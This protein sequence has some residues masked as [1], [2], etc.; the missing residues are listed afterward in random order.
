MDAIEVDD[1]DRRQGDVEDD[2]RNGIKSAAP[3][4]AQLF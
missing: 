3:E 1:D 2:R 4:K